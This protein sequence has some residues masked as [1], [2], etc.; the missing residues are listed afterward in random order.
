MATAL[1]RAKAIAYLK[2]RWV[3]PNDIMNAIL[4][5]APILG[6]F[7]KNQKKLGGRYM[8]VPIQRVG[9]VGRSASYTKSRTNT[10]GST[11][12]GFDV[13]YQS[14]YQVLFFDGDLLDDAAGDENAIADLMDGEV[15]SGIATVRKDI[16][17]S[18]F[19]NVGGAR[20]RIGSIAAGNA[21]ANC[22]IILL[23]TTDSKFFEEG[24]LL[25][26]S[27]NDGTATGHTLRAAGATITI[28]AI[29]RLLGYLEFASDVTVS[30][31]AIAA[32]DYLFAD[33]DFKSKFPGF[34]SW[35]PYVD[36]TPGES[37]YS[38]DR[39]TNV[40]ILSG[41]RYDAT[42]KP[43]EA[44]LVDAAAYSDLYDARWDMVAINPVRWGKFANSL[45]ADRANRLTDVSGSGKVTISYKAIMIST[46]FGEVP[47]FADGGCPLNDGLGLTKASWEFGYSGDD[48]V[49]VVDND[50]LIM[51]RETT[52]GDGWA[53]DLKSRLAL[54]C[55]QP[56]QNTRLAF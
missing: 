32:N 25:A 22:R 35:L 18:L 27:A 44:A 5:N 3:E 34:S 54:G 36:P 8:H 51:R 53:T 23:N 12:Q 4:V 41:L 11:Y 14:N 50:G 40:N 31:A 47:V 24:M 13:T 7:E 46:N 48:M 6:M 26:D 42:N 20:G 52:I 21:G 30:I 1:A 2:E 33:G 28:T 43:I 19:G 29:N 37:F 9:P 17:Q 15:K 38:V 56:G 45:G 39:S 49:H 55:K 16:Q 10:V